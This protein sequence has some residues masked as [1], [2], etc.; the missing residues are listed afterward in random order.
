MAKKK[1]VVLVFLCFFTTH[2]FSQFTCTVKEEKLK[3][4]DIS[5]SLFKN[6]KY[7]IVLQ[8]VIDGSIYEYGLSAGA[9]LYEKDTL[10]CKDLFHNYTLKFVKNKDE[11]FPVE[12]F[13][14]LTSKL[15]SYG[16]EYDENYKIISNNLVGYFNPLNINNNHYQYHKLYYR[17]YEFNELSVELK[18][19]DYYVCKIDKLIL[20]EGKFVYNGKYIKFY[21]KYMNFSFIG[22]VTPRG[23][24]VGYFPF[25]NSCLQ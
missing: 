14:Y 22:I 10:I 9:Y 1:F 25:N 4:I 15:I 24:C 21:D 13:P 2:V 16:Q 3:S 17:K 20:S 8:H 7:L 11:L 18:K 5:L 6:N 19:K 23:I 12:S